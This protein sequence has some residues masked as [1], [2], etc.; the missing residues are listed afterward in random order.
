M[1]QCHVTPHPLPRTTRVIVET[2]RVQRRDRLVAFYMST[3]VRLPDLPIHLLKSTGRAHARK[4][5]LCVPA[6][7]GAEGLRRTAERGVASPAAGT[8]GQRWSAGTCCPPNPRS[9][10]ARVGVTAHQ[11][12]AATNRGTQPPGPRAV[13]L[14]AVYPETWRIL[15][16]GA[17]AAACWRMH[18]WYSGWWRGGNGASTHQLAAGPGCRLPPEPRRICARSPPLRAHPGHQGEG[19]GARPPGHRRLTSGV[20]VSLLEQVVELRLFHLPEGY[21]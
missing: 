12:A 4:D 2:G 19:A 11:D 13:I 18:R 17:C 3:S 16:G 15:S 10:T 7:F 21:C 5:E 8:S 20:G 6:V 14:R 1:T 9:G